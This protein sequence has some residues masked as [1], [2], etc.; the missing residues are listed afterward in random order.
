[1]WIIDWTCVA[2]IGQV[3]AATFTAF[4]FIFIWL[5]IR[6]A[7]QIASADFILRLESEFKE[8]HMETFTKLV[9]GG[10]WSIDAAGPTNTTEIMELLHYLDF[11]ATLQLLRSE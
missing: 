1:M 5:Q 2:A 7:G 4:G 9:P 3:M 8:Y 6:K 11:F 10:I